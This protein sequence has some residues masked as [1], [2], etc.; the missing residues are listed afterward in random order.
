MTNPSSRALPP[1][2]DSRKEALDPARSVLVQAPAG[3][4]KTDL[5]TRRFLRLLAEVDDPSQVVAITFTRAADAEMRHR[6][7]SELEK[8]AEASAPSSDDPLDMQHLAH[9]ALARSRQRN[10]QLLDLP[11]QLR[12]TTIDAFC[13][14]I[15]LQQPLL[16]G[17]GGALDLLPRPDEFYR[18]AARTTLFQ[19]D[20]GDTSLAAAIRLLLLWRDNDLADLENLLVEMLRDR[21]RWMHGYLLQRDPD[22]DLLRLTF[23]QPFVNTIR[24]HIIFLDNIIQSIS[25]VKDEILLLARFAC[26]NQHGEPFQPLAE[27]PEFPAPPFAS[28]DSLEEARQAWLIAATLLLTNDGGFRQRIDKTLGFPAD[29]KAEKARLLALISK[30]R[31]V[32]GFEAALKSLRELPPTRYPDEEWDILR[33]SFTLLRHAAVQLLTVFA[34][35]SGVDYIQIAQIARHVLLDEEREPTEAAIA[36][37]DNIH[38]LLV[39]EFQDTS[40]SQHRLLGSLIAAWPDDAG[41]SLFVVGDPMQSIYYFRGADAELFPQVRDLGLQLP[42]S[43]SFPL[44]PVRLSANFR[45]DPALVADLNQVF[46][47][48]FAQDDGSGITFEPALPVRDPGTLPLPRRH[49]HCTF[50]PGAQAGNAALGKEQTA[51]L[52]AAATEAQ[53]ESMLAVIRAHMPLVAQA[54]ANGKPWRIAVLARAKKHLAPLALALRKAEIPFRAVELEDLTARPE[55]LD[56]LALARAILNPLDRVAWLGLLRAP[57]CGL[58]LAD[59]HILAGDEASENRPIPELLAE[60]QSS[61]SPEGQSAVQRLLHALASAPAFRTAQPL[62]TL[63]TRLQQLWLS[64]GGAACVDATALENL[65]L[66]WSCLDALPAGESDL[67]GPALDAA[68]KSLTAQPDAAASPDSG[69]Q[70]MTIHKSKGLEFEVVLVPELQASTR[71][72][73]NRRLLSWIERGLAAPT[74]EG[75]ITEF[76]VAPLHAKG[77]QTGSAR[78][79]VEQVSRR[80]E[81]QESRRLLYVAATRARDELHLFARPAYRFAGGEPQLAQPSKTLLATAWPALEEEIRAQ[82]AAWLAS[83]QAEQDLASAQQLATVS[84]AQQPAPSHPA[85]LHRLPAGFQPPSPAASAAPAQG[86]SPID[87]GSP[88]FNRHEGGLS[89]RTIGLAV[90]VLFQQLARL[91]ST[92]EMPAALES[93]PALLPPLIAQAR[94]AGLAPAQAKSTAARAIE[95]VA[96]AAADPIAQWILAPHPD[97][98]SE[99]AWTGLLSGS[100]RTVRVDRLFRAG[101]EPLVPGSDIWWI[102]DYKTAHADSLNLAQALPELRTLFAPQLQ[103]YAAVLRLLHGPQAQLRAALYYPR[104]LQF[105][106]WE[107]S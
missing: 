88:L 30:L 40:R 58:S 15:A 55:I 5:L 94:A 63:G 72:N 1:D 90:H 16:S 76:L 13:R 60:R 57:W 53:L 42:T 34:E 97:A 25:N 79:F 61:L 68:L 66:L 48:V 17:L 105:D 4:G 20:G 84:A 43:G 11:S 6:I 100:L 70:L 83:P 27:L 65:H 59:L 47:R 50:M 21:D 12:I 3:S 38:H 74:P 28:A 93:L 18:R 24:D 67:L 22:W 32:S 78:A 85:I 9:R 52:R 95:L 19:L 36:L 44:H 89:A 106:W 35:S 77:T 26:K 86:S 91:R 73:S 33:A 29:C 99:T 92:L 104:L 64:L 14:E 2:Q 23:Q 7:L 31:S 41:R 46:A 71:G 51:Q 10:W 69:V 49:L 37:A 81:A 8:A 98:A 101:P 54:R 87:A 96:R 82:F 80:H 107:I 75:E 102:V 62:A 103:A 56:A 45:T 39:D